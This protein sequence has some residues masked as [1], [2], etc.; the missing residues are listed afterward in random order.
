M[1]RE[2]VVRS[3]NRQAWKI[4]FDC[5]EDMVKFAEGPEK[6]RSPGA[7]R[8][9]SRGGGFYECRDWSDFVK[10][11]RK[12][13]PEGENF[14]RK[15]SNVLFEKVSSLIDHPTYVYDVE[16]VDFDI[17]RVLAGEPEV[18]IDQYPREADAPGRIV[19]VVYSVSASSGVDKSVMIARGASVAA[20][21][22]LLEFSGRTVE[23]VCRE[24]ADGSYSWRS[25][26]E[27]MVKRAGQPLNMPE[28]IFAMAH[29]DMLR[30]LCFAVQERGPKEIVTNVCERMYGMP[31]TARKSKQGD[32]YLDRMMYGESW[33]TEQNR[34]VEWALSALAAQG[35][36]VKK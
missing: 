31:S 33:W 24:D 25:E 20:I 35:V 22:Q 12:G 13:W 10:V 19:K 36:E 23:L 17:S 34:A 8:E 7:S 11:A 5:L 29:P 21:V 32:I 3:E 4:E 1:H 15:F 26:I 2:D 27:V 6:F 30:R 14:A 16:G 9:W 18:W 28:V